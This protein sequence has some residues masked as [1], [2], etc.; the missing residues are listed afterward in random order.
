[1]GTSPL[2]A[3]LWD[4][5]GTLAESERDGHLQAFNHAFEAMGLPWRWS[6]ERYGELLRITGGRERMMADMAQRSD[7][8][9]NSGD[10]ERLARELHAIKNKRYAELVG[11]GQLPLR[12]GVRELLDEATAAGIRQAITTTTSRSNVQALLSAQLGR[13]WADRFDTVLCGEDVQRKKPDPEVFHLALKQMSLSPVQAL[14][15]EDSPGG[16]V[17][18]RAAGVQVVVTRSVFFADA[19]VEDALA[20]GPGLHT[21]QGW[22]PALRGAEGRVGLDDLLAWRQASESVSQFG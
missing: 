7:A 13:H 1:M 19:P 5:D 11:Q 20:I 21:R 3:L 22:Q 15:L 9:G 17:A 6:E 18:A 2:Q 4:V 10:R 8:P 14:A 16:V 12:P